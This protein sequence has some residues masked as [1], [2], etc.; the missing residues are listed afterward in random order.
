MTVFRGPPAS[1]VKSPLT[2]IAGSS[3]ALFSISNIR[4]LPVE[5]RSLAGST[6]PMIPPK[7]DNK[8]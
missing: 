3:C 1:C 6:A 8:I 2:R 5:G 7:S 4:L